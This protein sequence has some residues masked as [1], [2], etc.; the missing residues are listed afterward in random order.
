MR[1]Q[2]RKQKK[3]RFDSFAGGERVFVSGR[4]T[5]RQTF[6]STGRG[7]AKKLIVTSTDVQ[8]WNEPS[9]R[10]YDRQN[11]WDVYRI[12]S[13]TVVR[14]CVFIIWRRRQK[15][16]TPA[17]SRTSIYDPP[18]HHALPTPILPGGGMRKR[19]AGLSQ[20]PVMSRR[21]TPRRSTRHTITDHSPTVYYNIIIS[22]VYEHTRHS[23]IITCRISRF[24]KRNIVL[25]NL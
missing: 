12:S 23:I 16:L 6:L 11:T 8:G 14:R 10:R 24:K 3:T 22:Y 19:A 5:C 21:H 2:V 15:R 9:C 7:E 25:E 1:D 4:Q 20:I 17:D 18:W 13:K